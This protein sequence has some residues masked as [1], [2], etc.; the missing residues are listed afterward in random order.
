MIQG[1]GIDVVEI[2]RIQQTI[3]RWGNRFLQKVF[4]G[5]ELRYCLARKNPTQHLAA[6]FAAKEAVSKALAT[7]W[8]GI[9]R[10]QDVEVVNDAIGK[11]EVRFLGRLGDTLHDRRVHISLSHAETIV[12]AVAVVE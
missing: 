12:V 2:N 9:F 5:T 11:P 8:S 1:I 7:G 10:W 4:T 3:E 6:R